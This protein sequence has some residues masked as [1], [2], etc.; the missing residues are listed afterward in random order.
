MKDDHDDLTLDDGD[1]ISRLCLD[2]ET[3]FCLPSDLEI[4]K[5]IV[6]PS[7]NFKDN[8][9]GTADEKK[10]KQIAKKREAIEEDDGLLDM[11][12]IA[13]IGLEADRELWHFSTAPQGS[14]QALKDESHLIQVEAEPAMLIA[15]RRWCDSHTNE[16]TRTLTWNGFAFDLSKLRH[17]FALHG[18]RL[19]AILAPETSN[20]H[21]DLMTIYANRYTVNKALRRFISQQTVCKLLK[22]DSKTKAMTDVAGAAFPQAWADGEYFRCCLYNLLDVNDLSEIGSRMGY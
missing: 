7:G 8:A 5:E 13:C 18:L 1:A 2:I 17:R 10:V 14:L 11:N 6:K 20:R 3:A 12:P 15:F 19:P 21:I 16:D 22:I 9:D 4:E